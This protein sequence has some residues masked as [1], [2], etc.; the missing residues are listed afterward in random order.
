M[1]FS[2]PIIKLEFA[3]LHAEHIALS[4][5]KKVLCFFEDQTSSL[6]QYMEGRMT[7]IV[8]RLVLDKMLDVYLEW[9]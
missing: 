6:V 7:K 2:L 1:F 3:S 4:S 9:E 8:A 5:N